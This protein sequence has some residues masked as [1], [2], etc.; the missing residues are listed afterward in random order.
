MGSYRASGEQL[1]TGPEANT[2]RACR[3]TGFSRALARM[4]RTG[5]KLPLSWYGSLTEQQMT[6]GRALTPIRRKRLLKTF[7]TF[8]AGYTHDDLERF[9]DLLYG[10]YSHVY[11]AAELRQIVV[12]DPF[13]RSDHPRQLK[14]VELTDW[15]E[16]LV[17]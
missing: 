11:T 13:D 7:G 5:P 8:P 15:L 9:L 12:C 2:F 3:E 4:H 10:L 14:L 1:R 16:A 6:E 17:T